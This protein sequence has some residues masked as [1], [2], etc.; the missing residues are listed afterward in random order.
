MNN[1]YTI[2]NNHLFGMTSTLEFIEG[3]GGVTKGQLISKANFQAVNS[4]KKLT[5]EFVFTKYYTTC[6]CSLF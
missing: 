5:N 6:F 4:S 1:G 3:K 2:P